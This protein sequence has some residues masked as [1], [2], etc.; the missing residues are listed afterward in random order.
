MENYSGLDT[1]SKS[2]Y[3]SSKDSVAVLDYNKDKLRLE[4][5]LSKDYNKYRNTSWN[6]D[7]QIQA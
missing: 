5:E 7:A 3:D 4:L 2:E 1:S 6:L